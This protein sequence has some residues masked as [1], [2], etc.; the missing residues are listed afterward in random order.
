MKVFKKPFVYFRTRLPPPSL[1][2]HWHQQ[3]SCLQPTPNSLWRFFWNTSK[4]EEAH[5]QKAHKIRFQGI[6]YLKLNK[7]R[8]KIFKKIHVST[9]RIQPRLS[10]LPGAGLLPLPKIRQ[11][12]TPVLQANS[13]TVQNWITIKCM[14]LLPVALEKF[15]TRPRAFF[16]DGRKILVTSIIP[17][18]LTS[19]RR[20]KM[21]SGVH[22]IGR[23][24]RIPALF[25]RPH[26]PVVSVEQR[27]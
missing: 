10:P 22:S 12:I 19:A 18:R 15:T 24:S 20:L 26:N 8:A 2:T 25:T 4:R 13:T 1:L 3:E 5:K 11:K 14:P 6:F 17:H 27:V 7:W 9:T 23:I 21:S 16:N